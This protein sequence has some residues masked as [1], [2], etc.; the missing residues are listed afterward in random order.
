M[1]GLIGQSTGILGTMFYES[2]LKD[3]EVRTVI[4]YSTIFS[5]VS[6]LSQ[7]AFASRW[8]TALGINDIVF[9]VLTDTVFGVIGLAM[10][11]LPTLALFAKITPPKIEGTVFAFLTGTTNLANNVLS[12]MVGVWMNEQF[13]GVTAENLSNYKQLCMIGLITSFLGFL[14]LP[15]IPLKADIQKF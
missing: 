8:N 12:P 10:N 7:Y 4:Y 1:L 2:R 3:L 5:V 15:L 13:I 11:T 6:S 14:I 9:I